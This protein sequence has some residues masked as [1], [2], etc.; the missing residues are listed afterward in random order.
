MDFSDFDNHL[1]EIVNA[2]RH[3][4]KEKCLNPNVF[5]SKDNQQAIAVPCNLWKCPVCA[6]KKAWKL[7]K[8]VE[9]AITQKDVRHLILTIPDDSYDITEMFNNLRTQLRERGKCKVYFWVKEFQ[10]RGV[11]HL[12]V[13]L[14]EYIHFTEIKTYW[15]GEIKINRVKGSAS[16]LTKYLS[17]SESQE[18]FEKGERRYS[19]SRNFFEK[20]VK[21]PSVEEWVF[22]TQRQLYE[23]PVFADHIAGLL[24]ND[25]NWVCDD[26][27]FEYL[28][29]DKWKV[30][31]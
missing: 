19:S 28:D 7:K 15:E 31:V 5:V 27:D 21:E 10:K 18:L 3:K 22:Y 13:M 25:P 17:K 12:H 8:R 30:L 16:Y 26:P 11:R 24:K 1:E 29:R 20:L 14:F 2:P 6:S 4:P 23:D 9:R